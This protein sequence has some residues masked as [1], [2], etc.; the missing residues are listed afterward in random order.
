M[1]ANTGHRGNMVL[2]TVYLPKDVD[3][4]LRQFAFQMQE[5]K[6]EVIR[7][8]IRVGLT[9]HR[10]DLFSDREELREAP[11]AAASAM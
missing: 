4:D 7:A 3:D 11:V 9:L 5:S 1:E 10:D 6:N 2:R 8:C